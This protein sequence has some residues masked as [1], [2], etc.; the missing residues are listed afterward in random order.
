MCIRDRWCNRID[1]I[2]DGYMLEWKEG[3]IVPVTELPLRYPGGKTKIYDKV[4]R[5]LMAF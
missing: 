1:F 4:K 5:F 3:R 2:E